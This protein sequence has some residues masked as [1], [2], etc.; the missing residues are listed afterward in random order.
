[1]LLAVVHFS[2]LSTFALSLPFQNPRGICRPNSLTH[3]STR[4]GL[5]DPGG[6]APLTFVPS[7]LSGFKELNAE[8]MERLQEDIKNIKNNYRRTKVSEN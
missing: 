7:L 5:R 8:Q 4:P 6:S 3:D 1:M 2:A